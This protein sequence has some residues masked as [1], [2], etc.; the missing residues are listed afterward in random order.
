M[1]TALGPANCCRAV[2]PCPPLRAFVALLGGER[3]AWARKAGAVRAVRQVRA[4]DDRADVALMVLAALAPA[5]DGPQAWR[6]W[7]ALSQS[8]RRASFG[9]GA[10]AGLARAK[11]GDEIDTAADALARYYSALHD[12]EEPLTPTPTEWPERASEKSSVF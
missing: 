5:G 2:A 3:G 8:L 7:V 4:L 9:V 12:A 11:K 1:A 10:L 6:A